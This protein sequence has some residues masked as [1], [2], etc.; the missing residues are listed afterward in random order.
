MLVFSRLA[1]AIA[2][3][4]ICA[5]AQAAPSTDDN[6]DGRILFTRTVLTPTNNGAAA[7]PS[8]AALF[9][10][11]LDGNHV[12]RLTPQQQG[13][14]YVPG[15]ESDTMVWGYGPVNWLSKNFS[16]GA[17]HILY[18]DGLSATFPTGQTSMSGKYKV[19]D[20]AGHAHALFPGPDDVNAGFGFV[21]WGPPGSNEI[22]Y[23]NTAMNY[24]ASPACVF[25][26]HPDGSSAH[27]LWCADNHA[28]PTSVSNLRWSGDGKSLLVYVNWNNEYQT[29][30]NWG[31]YPAAELWR[32]TVATG[33]ATRVSTMIYEP[34]QG[35][36]ADI[37]FD[38]N[39]VLYEEYA[40][41]ES[42]TPTCDPQMAEY[43]SSYTVCARDMTTGKTTM[44]WHEMGNGVLQ[45]AIAP[46]GHHM[47]ASKFN[48]PPG[49]SGSEADLYLVSTADG[50]VVRQ[51]TRRPAAG[52]PALSRVLWKLVAWSRDGQRLLV[53]RF[54]LPPP[55]VNK[56]TNPVQDI[57]V[58]NV[59]TGRARHVIGGNAEDWYQP[60]W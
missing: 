47:A 25:L 11:D 4:W 22:A 15:L 57:Y 38:G 5:A 17:R 24:P 27:R 40:P 53:N 30:P 10:V 9:T 32:I 49:V 13:H 1:V 7:F 55:V 26:I 37:S 21:T 29:P 12:R 33:A 35:D 54:Y 3:T 45:L 6:C 50:S 51:L 60:N 46:D 42:E 28:T 48:D 39:T 58:I 23:T 16:N 41:Y 8:S 2:A 20:M 59:A 56:I 34:A 44:L 19:M 52:L 36:S 43:G 18:F 14:F 31:Y